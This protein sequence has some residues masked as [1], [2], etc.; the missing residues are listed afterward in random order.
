MLPINQFLIKVFR[1]KLYLGAIAI[2]LI[3]I[4]TAT[5]QYQK[6]SQ[7]KTLEQKIKEIGQNTKIDKKTLNQTELK[8]KAK[9]VTVRIFATVDEH[10]IGGS[11][12]IIG[13]KNNQYLVLTN[14]HVINNKDINY[15]IETY[16]G[17]I[18]NAEVIWQNDQDLIVNDLALITFQS[19]VEYPTIKIKKKIATTK[20]DIILA[21]G[22]PFQNNLQQSTKIQYTLGNLTQILS[23][24]LMGGYQ[25]GY[26]NN[27]HSGMSGGSILN[28]QG[29]LIG[30][31]G[32]GK[33]PPF[34]N[35]YIYQNG[36][37]IPEKQMEMMSNLSWGIPSQSINE[38]INLVKTKKNL[39]FEIQQ[40]D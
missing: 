29:E 37:N 1:Q 18:Y 31:N 15:K 16:T 34:G 23:K 39:D 28:Q 38:L 4:L 13:R 40:V 32:L 26:T 33:Y 22:F 30:I 20:N 21:S 14:N 2:F 25:L 9:L 36:E 11:G 6:I 35:P 17:G 3:L 5:L 19:E 12:V 8:H 27:I 10:E 24:P 7:Q